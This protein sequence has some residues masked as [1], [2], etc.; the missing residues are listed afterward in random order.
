MHLQELPDVVPGLGVDVDLL[1]HGLGH[2]LVDPQPLRLPL[3]LLHR[4]QLG[5][6]DAVG[7]LA[8]PQLVVPGGN[9]IKTGLPGNLILSKRQGLL[10]VLFS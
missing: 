6:R 3:L 9:C 4:Q 5:R 7:A 1:L 2:V 10:E 8:H